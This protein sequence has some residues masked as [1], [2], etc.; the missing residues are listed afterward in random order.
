MSPRI[1]IIGPSWVG[2]MVMA[3]SLFKALKQHQPGAEIDVVAPTWSSPLLA[4]MP[5]ISQAIRLPLRHG[6][7]GL[8]ERWRLGRSLRGRYDQAIVL[9][10][11]WKSALVPYAARIP[12]RTG[13]LGE[14]RYGV[15]NDWRRLDKK[16][17]PMM[18][19][20]F[21]AL[22]H[23]ALQ[24]A[25]PDIMPPELVVR[26]QDV[27]VAMH[28]HALHQSEHDRLL[29]LCPGAE[30]GSAKRW[31]T[32]SF[33][34]LAM[35]YLD[36]GWQVWLF[37]SDKDQTTCAEINHLCAGRCV[38]L[39][40]KTSLA[41]AVDLISLAAAVVTND[42][43]LMHIAAALHR[44][45]VAIYGSTDPT[46]TPPLNER[47]T[48]IRLDLPCSPCFARECPL[49]HLACLQQISVNQVA[50]ALYRV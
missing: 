6:E 25:P 30:Y 22:A 41:E 1:L 46:F 28:R 23:P 36:Q 43:G 35:F 29:V 26:P 27:Q 15:L 24:D 42:S 40:G 21:T 50:E 31:P 47:H 8:G 3:Q 33:A 10:N 32:A 20:R 5:E 38:D 18:A 12:K 17:L 45:L 37:G 11:A 49:G 13:W 34:A 14:H 48:V 19:Q 2:D 44:P 39:S 9:P 16:R 4:R 7:L